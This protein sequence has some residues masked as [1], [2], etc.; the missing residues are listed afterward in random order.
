MI[1]SQ[2]KAKHI[3]MDKDQLYWSILKRIIAYGTNYYIHDGVIMMDRFEYFFDTEE[4]LRDFC[5]RLL[6]VYQ[7]FEE[8]SDLYKDILKV[9]SFETCELYSRYLG[10]AEPRKKISPVLDTLLISMNYPDLSL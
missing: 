5:L 9:L 2:L 8:K 3:T 4:A 6:N 10:S 1:T 7:L